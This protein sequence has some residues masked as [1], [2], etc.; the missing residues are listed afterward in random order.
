TSSEFGTFYEKCP[1]L[2]EEDESL[3]LSRCLLVDL[4]GRVIQQGLELLGI[5][6]CEQM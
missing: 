4:T 6:T 3:R 2:K 1:V 5:Q